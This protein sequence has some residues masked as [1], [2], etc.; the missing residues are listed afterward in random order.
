M[1]DRAERRFYEFGRF[2]LDLTDRVLLRGDEA[3]PLPPK[4]ADTLVFLV[5]NAGSVVDKHRL[6][7]QVWR[8]AFVEE[9]SLTRTISILRKAL[10]D[11]A[12]GREFISTIPTRGYRFATRMER[13]SIA[14]AFL[15]P[16]KSCSQCF[17][18]RT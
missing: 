3:I 4:A 9:G 12:H 18:L 1:A 7:K 14:P 17:P 5:Q 10:D 11:G 16:S 15:H 2:R 13:V 8:D 6:L